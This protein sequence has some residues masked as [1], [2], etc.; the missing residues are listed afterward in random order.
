MKKLKIIL[1]CLAILFIADYSQAKTF[2]SFNGRYTNLVFSYKYKLWKEKD[3]FTVEQIKSEC[4]NQPENPDVWYIAGYYWQYRINNR[5][6]AGE[7]YKKSM[8]LAPAAFRPN[9]SFIEIVRLNN[10]PE[11]LFC[12]LTNSFY[13]IRNVNNTMGWSWQINF[14]RSE[15]TNQLE[16]LYFFIQKN[17]EKIPACDYALGK[18]AMQAGK[19]KSALKHFEKELPN[20]VNRTK[21]NNILNELKWP[22]GYADNPKLMECRDKILKKY[23]SPFKYALQ[24]INDLRPKHNN[25][26]FYTLT[27]NAFE[28]AKNQRERIIA[29][30][31]FVSYCRNTD[32]KEIEGFINKIA[33]EKNVDPI[34]A[35]MLVRNMNTMNATNYLYSYCARV[36]DKMPEKINCVNNFIDA[37]HND[38]EGRK[39]PEADKYVLNLIVNKF[40]K[41]YSI[42]NSVAE[43]Y[44]KYG[45]YNDELACRKKMLAST[46]NEDF[47][48]KTKAR[49]TELKLKS[50]QSVDKTKF[51]VENLKNAGRDA[52][53]AKVISE[54]YLK[55]GKTNEALSI[56]MKCAE[57]KDFPDESKVAAMAI[58]NIKWGNSEKKAINFLNKLI[59]NNYPLFKSLAGKIMW[60]YID[61]GF[62]KEAVGMFVFI[63]KNDDQP[64]KYIE[65]I[66]DFD[67]NSFVYKIIS[68]KVTNSYI[69]SKISNMLYTYNNKHAAYKLRNYFINLPD[70]NPNKYFEAVEM[71]KYAYLKG[72]IKLCNEVIDKIDDLVN[73]EIVPENLSDNLFYYMMKLNL[74]NKCNSWVE[75]MLENT[76]S[77]KLSENLYYYSKWYMRI[78]ETNKLKNFVAKNCNTNLPIYKLVETLRVFNYI[79]ETNQYEL[80]V[81]AIGTRLDNARLVN[82]YGCN[83]LG[84][85][86]YLSRVSEKN[87]DKEINDFL[88][89]WFYNDEISVNTKI[90]FLSYAKSNKVDFINYIVKDKDKLNSGRLANIA[91]MFIRYGNTNRAIVLY[92][93]ALTKPDIREDSKINIITSLARIYINNKDYQSA[94]NELDKISQLNL[95]K[96]KSWIIMSVADL[97]AN[98]FKY[99]KAVDCYIRLINTA[100]NIRDVK[101]AI[102]RI[103]GLWH[104]DSEIEYAKLA[105][106]DFTNKNEYLNYTAK[107]LFFLLANNNS[108]A[109]KYILKAGEK[110]KTNEE[111]FSLWNTCC[112]LVNNNDNLQFRLNAYMKMFDLTS[113]INE[114][115]RVGRKINYILRQTKDYETILKINNELLNVV[116]NGCRRDEIIL[117]ISKTYMNLGDTNA[118][119]ETVLQSNDAETIKRSVYKLNKRNEMLAEFEKK[120]ETVNGKNFTIMAITL[121]Q[122]NWNN[123]ELSVKL[124]SL[125]DKKLPVINVR[126]YVDLSIIYLNCGYKNKAKN[127]LEKY[128][129]SLN[130]KYQKE[131]RKMIVKYL[132]LKWRQS[133]NSRGYITNSENLQRLW[134][135]R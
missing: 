105:E 103:S 109:E 24:Q 35:S 39:K 16:R 134:R 37:V 3:E 104:H 76:G 115:Y 43:K 56:L 4:Q 83:Y 1:F 17:K 128:V 67:A 71:L 14:F 53:T 86:N 75:F 57:N 74:T 81:D 36:I 61:N 95:E 7:C 27:S 25:L 92:S 5:K 89:K 42:I 70:K 82:S 130:E 101:D 72:D 133:L 13:K 91:W 131:G 100:K 129:D 12:N 22:S 90:S 124:A 64:Y 132:D 112:N 120:I 122:Y 118:A 32:S 10:G 107:A 45:C 33:K 58:I 102:N 55:A 2:V 123:K 73:R 21:K 84:K 97:Y 98:S 116:T 63:T 99:L 50:G 9:N 31:E 87:Y 47:I 20:T 69:L 51:I 121:S 62:E 108:E 94:V 114:K 135:R 96:Q 23:L 29:I 113:N 6:K 30:H 8:E 85:L 26:R 68:E 119:W 38:N 60:K 11:N 126:D 48:S 34:F 46:D 19:Y 15:N 41:N 59:K 88:Q 40:P 77:K 80:F 117:N 44:K 106:T 18:C 52:S 111:K 49:I 54:F 66:K 110:L 65:A 125:L 78:G 79:R 93:Y 127:L 28:L